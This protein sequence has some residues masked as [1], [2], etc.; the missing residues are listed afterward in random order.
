[1]YD[2]S[3]VKRAIFLQSI[4]RHFPSDII[5]SATTTM[6]MC[7]KDH[8]TKDN[9]KLILLKELGLTLL[10][11]PPKKNQPKLDYLNFGWE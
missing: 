2:Q 6:L 11:S 3:K 4:I 1:M 7:I 8:Y 10:K 5:A 9:E